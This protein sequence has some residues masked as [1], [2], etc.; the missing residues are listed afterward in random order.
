VKYQTMSLHT[1]QHSNG[2]TYRYLTRK[3][4]NRAYEISLQQNSCCFCNTRSYCAEDLCN[5]VESCKIQFNTTLEENIRY[6]SSK[7]KR[8]LG[9]KN[10]KE[11]LHSLYPDLYELYNAVYPYVGKCQGLPPPDYIY[12]DDLNNHIDYVIQR[13]LTDLQDVV[14]WE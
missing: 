10:T 12:W 9:S 5:C 6:D 7:R 13:A 1:T 2:N 8:N 3:E 14:F 11:R 4:K